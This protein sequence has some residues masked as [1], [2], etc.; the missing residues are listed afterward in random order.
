M[1]TDRDG[2][3][4]ATDADRARWVECYRASGTG[5][6]QFAT[7][8]GLSAGQLHYWVYGSR[9]RSAEPMATPV[10]RE[11]L[12]SGL[13]NAHAP[14]TAEIGLPDGTTVR[15][16]PTADVTWAGTLI[17]SLRRPCSP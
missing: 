6:K 10:F 13:R 5:L 9:R 8:H 17:E 16:S 7:E 1:N 11:V 14:W 4:A 3:G 2:R 12:V 15:L